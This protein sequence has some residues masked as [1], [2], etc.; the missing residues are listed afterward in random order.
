MKVVL[1]MLFLTFHDTN[2]L[3][4][5]QDLTWRSYTLAE[6]LLMTKWVQIIGR[7]KF[8]TVVL[9]PDKETFVM[10]VAHLRA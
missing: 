3:F 7:K 10:Y 9:D 2:M 8:V 1:G 4:V 6:T 5:K